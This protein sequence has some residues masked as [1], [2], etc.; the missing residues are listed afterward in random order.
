[1]YRRGLCLILATLMTM[2]GCQQQTR[3]T[4]PH[5]TADS[6]S[7]APSV[8]SAPR[9][10]TLADLDIKTSD[11]KGGNIQLKDPLDEDEYYCFDVFGFGANAQTVEPLSVH[12]CKPEGWRDATF[13]MDYPKPGQIYLPAYDLC[14]QA[15]RIERGAHIMLETCS[16]TPLQQ[17]IY[18]ADGTLEMLPR[19]GRDAF[20]VV[21]HPADGIATGGPS[22]LRREVYIY[23]CDRIDAALKQWVLP[24]GAPA[25]APHDGIKLAP[26]AGP[27]IPPE[28]GP[29]AGLYQAV[30]SGCHGSN[31]EGNLTLQSPKLAGQSEWYLARSFENYT[32]GILG[33]RDGDRW[34]S[35][36]AYHVS[37]LP[38]SIAA[39]LAA[40]I[41]L[42]PDEPA[43][44]L[45]S[46]NVA[47]GKQI[48]DEYC[49]LC[50]ADDAMGLQALN[51]PR[52]AGMSDWYLLRQMHKFKDGRRGAHEQDI[53]G[54]QMAAI[55]GDLDTDQHMIDVIA[56]VNT[57]PSR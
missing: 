51:S 33:T 21:V 10:L 40:Y 7:P 18:R 50:H 23:N 22:H 44:P 3:S 38:S 11:F 32:A 13:Q 54:A 26:P 5:S 29:I 20:C 53:Y 6:V 37:D 39:D 15:T 56:Y 1:M 47:N 14:A 25:L 19:H 46:G 55:M 43:A 49:A 34:G 36:M 2:G 45:V 24:S 17:F 27:P 30:C 28:M 48:Y 42:M 4:S 41:Q 35:Q 31:G 16:D 9:A 57:L 12:T 52:L 8:P